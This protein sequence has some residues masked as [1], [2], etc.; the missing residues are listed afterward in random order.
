MIDELMYGITPSA[1]IVTRDRLPPVNMSYIPNSVFCACSE[2][3]RIAS[4][5]T[6]G[7][8]MK[9]P[10]RYTASMPSVNNTRLRRSATAK[11]FFSVS[12]TRLPQLAADRLCLTTRG[13]QLLGGLSAELVR[14]HGQ[15]L[16]D[17][18]TAQ[19]LDERG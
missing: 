5:L 2:R 1:K 6:P 8:G 9:L 4:E 15:R 14:L 13:G 19:H 12:S 17:L 7:V 3:M 18:T 16:G 11:R 10:T